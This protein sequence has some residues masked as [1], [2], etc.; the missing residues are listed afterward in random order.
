MGVLGAMGRSLHFTVQHGEPVKGLT[1]GMKDVIS[2]R[3]LESS[4]PHCVACAQEEGGS[5]EPTQQSA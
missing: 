4:L 1:R 5:W 2:L 3:T